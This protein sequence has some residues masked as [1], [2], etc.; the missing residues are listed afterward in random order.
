[1]IDFRKLES[2][3]MIGWECFR[4]AELEDAVDWQQH[5]RLLLHNQC[6]VMVV[7]CGGLW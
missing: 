3:D 5:L 7:Y 1:M 4:K 6:A 2:E